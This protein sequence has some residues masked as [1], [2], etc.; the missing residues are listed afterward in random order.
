MP[1][2]T[3][4]KRSTEDRTLGSLQRSAQRKKASAARKRKATGDN[5]TLASLKRELQKQK[6]LVTREIAS[7]DRVIKKKSPVRKAAAPARGRP[8]KGPSD[9][10]ARERFDRKLRVCIIRKCPPGQ[11]R[12]PDTKRCTGRKKLSG[13]NKYMRANIKFY[14]QDPKWAKKPHQAIFA[15]CAADWSALSAAQKKAYNK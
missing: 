3:P 11:R 13:Y 4:R 1:S 15:A 2:S 5:Q 10:K 14:K 7:I 6:T 9:C 8:A 12:D